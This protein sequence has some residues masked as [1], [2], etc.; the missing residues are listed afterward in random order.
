MRVRARVGVS[1]RV[2]VRRTKTE[3]RTGWQDQT[4]A[5]QDKGKRLRY[6]TVLVGPQSSD[7]QEPDWY[8]DV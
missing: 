7:A 4:N 5:R 2:R 6:I 8:M 3:T 1:V